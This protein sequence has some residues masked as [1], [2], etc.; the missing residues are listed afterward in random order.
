[1]TFTLPD[2]LTHFTALD[3]FAVV[4]LLV[5]WLGMTTYIERSK[6]SCLSTHMLM[7]SYRVR[8][9]EQMVTRQP[10]VFDSSILAIMRNG[11]T[12]FASSC[13]IALGGCVAL[14]GGA[15]QLTV[16]ASDLS[17]NL[18]I[19]KIVWEVKILLLMVLLA[20]GFLKFVWSVRL[21]G[22]CAIVMAAVPNDPTDP[23]T[24]PEARKAADIANH[25][26]RSFNRG[27]RSVYFTIA[28]LTWMIGAAAF[29]LAVCVTVI[30]LYRR[31]YSSRT[32]Q[33]LSS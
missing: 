15:E 32:R 28:A 31:E 13:M 5:A 22:Y 17:D 21:F 1:M 3:A 27:M 23:L 14:L 12:F 20:N 2:I 16:L 9:M 29:I 18:H 10:R 8:W 24:Q 6:A 30:V 19:P 4:C 26:A 7:E 11:A 25:A 33:V